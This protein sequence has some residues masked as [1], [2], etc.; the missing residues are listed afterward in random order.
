MS[1]LVHVPNLVVVEKLVYNVNIYIH[2]ALYIYIYKW[3][4]QLY[5]SFCLL[6]CNIEGNLL[7]STFDFGED[8]NV[9]TSVE[10]CHDNDDGI[11]PEDV[12]EEVNA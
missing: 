9:Y 8:D 6:A 11:V 4:G 12:N 7:E 1:V 3:L 10:G 2:L 5:C